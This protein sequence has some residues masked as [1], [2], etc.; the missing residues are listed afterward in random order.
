M[1]QLTSRLIGVVDKAIQPL[2]LSLWLK[3]MPQKI[4]LLIVE[5]E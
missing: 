1:N 2:V 5:R 3:K 4:L